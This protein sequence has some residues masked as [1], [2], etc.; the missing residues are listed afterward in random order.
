VNDS[1][2]YF[3]HIILTAKFLLPMY[4]KF[5]VLN[6]RYRISAPC[7]TG[8]M[9]EIYE[10][11]DLHTDS[12]VA[13]KIFTS[14]H[15]DLRVLKE[16]FNRELLALTQ[17][18]HPSIVDL[19]DN[20]EDSQTGHQFLVLEW[21]DTDLRKLL[22]K[23][24][25]HDWD[26][27]YW[28]IIRP[29]LEGL[30]FAHSRD[31]IHRDVKPSNI[32]VDAAGTAKLTDFGVSKLQTYLGSSLT[33][34]DFTSPPYSPPESD[35]GSYSATRDIFGIS[36]VLVECLA[37][38][39]LTTYEEL[40]AAFDRIPLP[41]QVHNIVKRALATDPGK[42]QQNAAVF[43]AELDAMQEF[44]GARSEP[45][46]QI[47]VEISPNALKGLFIM[48]PESTREE[49]E[50]LLVSDLNVVCGMTSIFEANR[51]NSE[52]ITLFGGSFICRAYVALPDEDHLYIVSVSELSPT[53]VERRR[54]DSMAA[55]V[56]FKRGRPGLSFA[57]RESI[58]SL[59][60]QLEGFRLKRIAQ[61][62]QNQENKLF[63]LWSSVLEA[64]TAIEKAKENPIKYDG[65]QEKG[66]RILF[67]TDVAPDGGLSGQLRLVKDDGV[68]KVTGE[69]EFATKEQISL[70][71]TNWYSKDLPQ[72][73]FLSI[74]TEA[75]LLAIQRQQSALR[76]IRADRG[77]RS[78]LGRLC[79]HPEKSRVPGAV[80][81]FTPIQPQI[82]VPKTS[83]VAAALGTEDFLVVEGP[84][85]TGKTTFIAEL[86]LQ[87]AKTH[88]NR[89]ILLTSQTHVALD[90][91]LEILIR[92]QSES[93]IVRIGRS[94]NPRISK[95]VENVLLDN[96]LDSWRDEVLL[97]GR[98]F[99]ER[100][101]S[102]HG[103]SPKEVLVGIEFERLAVTQSDLDELSAKTN[104]IDAQLQEMATAIAA[105]RRTRVLAADEEQAEQDTYRSLNDELAKLKAETRTRVAQREAIRAK[106]KSL[107]ADT[108][109][110]L[111][112]SAVE[113]RKWSELY[114]PH[115]T[116]N[117]QVKQIFE[118]HAEWQAR[119][120]RTPDFQ[121]ALLRSAQVVAGTCIGIAAVKAVQDLDFDLCIVDEASKATPT[122]MLVPLSRSRRWIVVGDHKQLPPFL[123]EGLRDPQLLEK[124]G[125]NESL[126]RATFFDRLRESLPSECK[127]FL[128]MQYRMVP[129]IGDLIS[130]CFYDDLL[131]SAPR[132]WNNTF[133]KILR[134]PVVW[135]ST[136]R[137]LKRHDNQV[138][139]S[140]INETE[141]AVIH[142]L[143]KRL[144]ATAAGTNKRWSI[145]VLSGYASQLSALEGRFATE[146]AKCKSLD[147]Q[148]N[149]V[150][151]VQGREAD[152]T[153]Y[154]V[155]RS[156][157]AGKLG[158]LKDASRLNV[159]LSRAKDYLI[160]VGDH[161]F[162]LAAQG[163]NPFRKVIQYI[164]RNP[165]T[166]GIE[167]ARI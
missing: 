116:T 91:A 110:L 161:E 150:D 38:T 54:N 26:R 47:F 107:D 127:A 162:F 11:R 68:V 53:V 33:L 95:A 17:L 43:L 118:T 48:H 101:A 125:L 92:T 19:L 103:I 108:A 49:L 24:S 106:L 156:N 135:L 109:P 74:D 148:W 154:S 139:D 13:V 28:S 119:F 137:Q 104:G 61:E 164:E 78:D 57:G 15:L 89:R 121:G 112:L 100:W 83:A 56:L 102:E 85:G 79:V 96:V 136:S 117:R 12:K 31:V 132:A 73:G 63:R 126:V 141:V 60:D 152:V 147:I 72:I 27:L 124:H 142:A 114:L 77:I 70:Y 167:E 42:R 128:S 90:N 50:S 36:A 22:Q 69:V 2:R 20:G 153:I 7:N 8:G 25:I 14:G 158:F 165:K 71:V 98:R 120:G 32:L 113:L 45:K 140:Y 133:Q 163:E 143:L 51:A 76:T 93:K 151:A 4:D 9:S 129:G 87:C 86:I 16:S 3:Q 115:N 122:E 65:Y 18:K 94:D 145:A 160:L 166:C 157:P 44:R 88:P 62:A 111:G 82:D 40:Y 58:N 149:T 159:A 67:S 21:V 29:L 146:L 59:R 46:Q 134:K 34:K 131:N 30:A 97:R 123:D 138:G 39:I 75:A 35:D 41:I 6:N 155:T 23:T 84:P 64:K 144:A 81:T 5:R 1:I 66:H 105:R 130:H 55:N 10:A 52:T 99:I 37:Q 80:S